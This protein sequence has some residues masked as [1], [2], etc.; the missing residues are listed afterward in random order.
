MREVAV[1]KSSATSSSV[2]AAG[3]LLNHCKAMPLSAYTDELHGIHLRCGLAL[4]FM[5]CLHI[6]KN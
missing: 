1:L 5:S 4:M 2:P 3:N 6:E